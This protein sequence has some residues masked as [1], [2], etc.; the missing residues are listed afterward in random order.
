LS[1]TSS[2][3]DEKLV[4]DSDVIARAGSRLASRNG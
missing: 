2:W 1:Y 3:L 4:N